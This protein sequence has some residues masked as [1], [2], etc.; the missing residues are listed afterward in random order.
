MSQ[1]KVLTLAFKL[2]HG[3]YEKACEQKYQM[4]VKA[5]PTASVSVSR[6]QLQMWSGK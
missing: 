4:L 3:R 2:Y 5:I 6:F 1:K